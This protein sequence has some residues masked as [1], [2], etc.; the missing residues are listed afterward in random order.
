MLRIMRRRFNRT[1]AFLVFSLCAV[2]RNISGCARVDAIGG[3]KRSIFCNGSKKF[4]KASGDASG[5]VKHS[6]MA[7]R[8]EPS[9]RCCSTLAVSSCSLSSSAFNYCRLIVGLTR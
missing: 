7:F 2:R 3:L 6:T 1:T 5:L 4:S 9:S 8:N